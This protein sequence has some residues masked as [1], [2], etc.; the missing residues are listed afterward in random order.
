MDF[1][2]TAWAL[3]F[4]AVAV[5]L[6]LV[7]GGCS[8]P[9]E[10]LR[11]YLGLNGMDCDEL[12]ASMIRVAEGLHKREAINVSADVAEAGLTAAVYSGGLPVT[13]AA[14]PVVASTINIPEDV[15]REGLRYRA[16]VA[17]I[18]GCDLPDSMLEVTDS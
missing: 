12:R 16:I 18:K 3:L 11:P 6:L 4:A 15:Y 13:W 14:A 9:R 17:A 8:G 1:Q 2:K 10:S 5:L 7:L